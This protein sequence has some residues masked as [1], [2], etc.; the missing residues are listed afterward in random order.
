VRLPTGVVGS[1][2]LDHLHGPP[3]VTAAWRV[4]ADIDAIVPLAAPTMPELHRAVTDLN[5]RGRCRR[6]TLCCGGC[7]RTLPR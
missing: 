3:W 2:T 4:A 1:R 6:R 7:G 5:Q